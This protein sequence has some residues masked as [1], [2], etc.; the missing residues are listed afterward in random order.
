MSMVYVIS[1]EGKP[2]MPTERLG[3]VR[4]LLKE[5][6]AKIIQYQPFTIQLLYESTKYVQPVVLGVDCGFK[7]IGISALSENGK[8][9]YAEEIEIRSYHVIKKGKEQKELLLE[10]RSML[11]RG[12]RQRKTRYRPARFDYRKKG[13]IGWLPPTILAKLDTHLR[14]IMNKIHKILPITKQI[15]EVG[16]FDVQAI[17]NTEIEGVEYQN[18]RMKGF[19]SVKEYVRIRDDYTC[20]YADLRK[21]IPCSPEYLQNKYDSRFCH[22]EHVNPKSKGGSN[23]PE[24]L[25]C[26]CKAHND[27]KGTMSY[28]EFTGKSFSK[29]KEFKE[30]P[31]MNC[32]KNH[33]YKRLK[34]VFSETYITYGFYTRRQ[35]NKLGLKKSHVNDAIAITRIIPQKE[36][37]YALY[38]TKQVRKK[39]RSL[40]Q[41][42]PQ[43]GGIRQKQNTQFV[44]VKNKKWCKWDK[45]EY[46]GQICFI[47][48][49]AK[50]NVYLKDINSNGIGKKDK[51]GKTT[52]V[53]V[54]NIKLLSR[55]NN[56][57]TNKI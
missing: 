7:Y 8:I 52:S 2:L 50:N 3:R 18:G 56:F 15:I 49:F 44:V 19:D 31:F 57:I 17:L 33:L 54:K 38:Q 25:V 53:A 13:C 14:I 10:Y 29:V 22:V 46:S 5:G 48:G 40:H 26:S 1:K 55:N 28:K 51:T 9:L 12:R 30:M 34:E 47:S 42:N 16:Q 11:R 39:N 27:A 43:K 21:D 35:R 32:L 23:R 20:H 45:V 4:R 37:K 41:A 6:K 24:N 36:Q